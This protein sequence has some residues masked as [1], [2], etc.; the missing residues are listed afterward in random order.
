MPAAAAAGA[1]VR[2]DRARKR[3][4]NGCTGV[5][6]GEDA[7]GGPSP[8]LSPEVSAGAGAVAEAAPAAG[9]AVAVAAAAI[10]THEP[11]ED[12]KG[13]MPAGAA[14]DEISGGEEVTEPGGG[15][16]PAQR[17]GEGGV[18]EGTGVGVGVVGVSSA[19]EGGRGWRRLLAGGSA[20]FTEEEGDYAADSERSTDHESMHLCGGGLRESDEHETSEREGFRR[21]P[22]DGGVVAGLGADGAGGRQDRGRN[23]TRT[24][25]YRDGGGVHLESR[26]SSPEAGLG[27]DDGNSS[28]RNSTSAG[29][30]GR[31]RL[32][33]CVSK[34]RRVGSA[35]GSGGSGGSGGGVRG[36]AGQEEAG[37]TSELHAHGEGS[38]TGGVGEEEE[39]E[40]EEEE[41][42]RDEAG[43]EAVETRA[44][45]V[46]GLSVGMGTGT[47]LEWKAKLGRQPIFMSRGIPEKGR[48][49]LSH[50][51]G[52]THG[53]RSP[54]RGGLGT[55]SGPLQ[56]PEDDRDRASSCS[57]A[58]SPVPSTIRA[59]CS[60]I[61]RPGSRG[62]SRA[63]AGLAAAAAA[64]DDGRGIRSDTAAAIGRGM[65]AAAAA[66]TAVTAAVVAGVGAP[67]EAR[68]PPPNTPGG[69]VPWHHTSVYEANDPTED[70]HAE[71]SHTELGV[72]IYCVCDGHG[73][74]RAAQFVCDHLAGDVLARV[75]A[76][77]AAAR[78][79]GGLGG[80]GGGDD[81]WT[82]DEEEVRRSLA[83]AFTSCDEQFI[84]QLDP[85]KNRGY[86]NAGCC[87]LLA[88]LI[89]SKLYVAH[90]G[91]CRIVLGTTEADASRFPPDFLSA[92]STT[93]TS[94]GAA[95]AVGAAS[96][97]GGGNGRGGDFGRESGGFRR[98][99][100]SVTPP[101]GRRAG[102]PTRSSPGG[103]LGAVALSRDHNCDDADEVALVRAR[104]GDEKA[105]RVSRNDQYKGA[106]AIKRVAG[107]LA[108]TR[109]VGDAYLKK[110]AFS[111]SPYKASTPCTMFISYPLGRDETSR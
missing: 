69:A 14:A 13:G 83:D 88:L 24:A 62:A 90:V 80:G 50:S 8:L 42:E 41:L 23:S 46:G 29:G 53:T 60:I 102:C 57:S 34:R 70:R 64:A 86:I 79:R 5:S 103:G 76:M 73:G 32:G 33:T 78:E 87:V 48:G 92:A 67:R 89:R 93:V 45:A 44:L 56:D 107:S 16:Q 63:G 51:E 36:G 40:E 49:L 6:R 20:M 101:G 1:E 58:D 31:S 4:R 59:G 75:V 21:S 39:E 55:L 30:E 38:R 96:V 109:A 95:G 71:V 85:R 10:P 61:V 15:G 105:I 77:A 82:G 3:R 106:R 84:A 35:S 54:G 98:A 2:H 25:G 108:V 18:S 12:D 22:G 47:P 65:A 94:P 7:A 72:R 68:A 66:T 26:T 37:G 104:S 74:S 81:G 99:T 97:A 52:E 91:D 9:A 100:G 43:T 28:G 17:F 19:G 11:M 110:A 27:G 111:F